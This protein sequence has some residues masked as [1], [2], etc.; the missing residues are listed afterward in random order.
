MVFQQNTTC[1]TRDKM[2]F[3]KPTS[4]S[5]KLLDFNA[6][7]VYWDTEHMMN[8]VPQMCPEE[9]PNIHPEVLVD[10]RGPAVRVEPT[11]DFKTHTSLN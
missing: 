1:V 2:E 8:K 10:G 11:R 7:S 6:A 3:S 9:R 4:A 5:E